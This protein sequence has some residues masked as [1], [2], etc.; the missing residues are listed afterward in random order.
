M[1]ASSIDPRKS[2]ISCTIRFIITEAKDIQGSNGLGPTTAGDLQLAAHQP[3]TVSFNAVLN[4]TDA[5][6]EVMEAAGICGHA[7]CEQDAPSLR[8]IWEFLYPC[9]L[10]VASGDLPGSPEEQGISLVSGQMGNTGHA[11]GT[12][13]TACSCRML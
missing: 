7:D 2:P 10:L 1:Q 3:D 12:H 4:A 8:R 13:C 11:K 9:D 6:E 5:P